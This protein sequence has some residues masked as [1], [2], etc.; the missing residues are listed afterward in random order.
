MPKR[1]VPVRG[2][3]FR[4]L[5]VS[6]AGVYLRRTKS[7]A[8]ITVTVLVPLLV[9]LGHATKPCSPS[10]CLNANNEFDQAACW[11][12]SD[13]VAVGHI[14]KV[15]HRPE[16][17]PTNKDFARFS[18]RVV[19]W[20]KGGKGRDREL[21]FEV[22]W[23]ENQKELPANTSGKFRFYGKHQ[24]APVSGSDQYYYFEALKE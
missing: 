5:G 22:G 6:C 24:P 18:F 12:K 20:E 15:V 2:R 10:P 7:I 13:W 16:Q 8:A 19:R 21:N 3:Q 9:S 17:E 1:Q 4:S 23:C 14:S 11:A